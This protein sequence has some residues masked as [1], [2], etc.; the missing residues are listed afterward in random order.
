MLR[1]ALHLF[2]LSTRHDIH[3][4]MVMLFFLEFLSDDDE[5]DD[6]PSK[7]KR[8]YYRGVSW[9]EQKQK[10]MCHVYKHNKLKLGYFATDKKAAQAYDK[11][12]P[13]LLGPEAKLNFPKKSMDNMSESEMRQDEGL[14]E[15]ACMICRKL[16]DEGFLLCENMEGGDHGGHF[17]CF[18]L[19]SVPEGDWYCT[20]H[21]KPEDCKATAPICKPVDPPSAKM[22]TISPP[23]E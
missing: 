6:S 20:L 8:S 7:A 22:P 18:G 16:D 12:L 10:W 14:E 23:A 21:K 13:K 4:N 17:R 15:T 2:F 3:I 5:L 19:S 9:N 11:T 1:D